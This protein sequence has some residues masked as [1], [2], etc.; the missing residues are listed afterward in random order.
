MSDWQP[1]ETAPRD[2]TRILAFG[3]GLG[4]VSDVVSYNDSVGCWNAPSDTLDDR[5][6][7]P[8]GY[9]RPTHWMPLPEAPVAFASA[10]RKDE[11]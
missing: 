3:G 11:E 7:E 4:E 9:N 1:I 10:Y 8:D 6:D 5:D 2:G